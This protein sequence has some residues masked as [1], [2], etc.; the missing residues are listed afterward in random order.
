[1]AGPREHVELVINCFLAPNLIC[2]NEKGNPL[3]CTTAVP[4][5]KIPVAIT[6]NKLK[7]WECYKLKTGV[8]NWACYQQANAN[9]T[10][11]GA[12]ASA[13]SVSGMPMS[14]LPVVPS[15]SSSYTT[16]EPVPPITN[17]T[18]PVALN[19]HFTVSY[20][21]Y[22]YNPYVENCKYFHRFGNNVPLSLG[23]N[24]STTV[25]LTDEHG[26]GIMCPNQE[27]FLSSIDFCNVQ[28][29]GSA[30]PGEQDAY[31]PY[32]MPRHFTL[33]FRQRYVRSPV[34]LQDIF[35]NYALSQVAGYQG[36]QNTVLEVSMETGR[37]DDES[38]PS[39]MLNPT[40]IRNAAPG[41]AQP[42]TAAA[43]I[44]APAPQTQFP[45][46]PYPTYFSN[47]PKT[48]TDGQPLTRKPIRAVTGTVS[49]TE[50]HKQKS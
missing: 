11:N 25:L 6:G 49:E 20:W 31:M 40:G 9:G 7:I 16:K 15:S 2:P 42:S 46:F 23:D 19:S 18:Q 30:P 32:Q 44:K 47:P 35:E 13:W 38:G 8:F 22:Q 50:S 5:Q 37:E 48:D 27:V 26:W 36:E 24:N 29:I 3:W 4:L 41:G 33:Y 14:M 28:I 39:G 43:L 12:S 45:H 1:M 10:W 17:T 34:V 21:Q